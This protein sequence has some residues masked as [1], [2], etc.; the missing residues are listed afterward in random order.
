MRALTAPPALPQ[1]AAE[2]SYHP[3]RI[4]FDGVLDWSRDAAWI[5]RFIRAF[6]F[7]P[8]PAAKTWLEGREIQLR[9][10]VGIGPDLPGRGPGEIVPGD[11]DQ[12]AVSCGRGSLTVRNVLVKGRE[13]ALSDLV[14][15]A[16][17]PWVF[18]AL[19]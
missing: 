4:P 11:G 3:K 1:N 18:Q 12:A 2:A 6:T 14:R 7:P 19:P 10:P 16:A 5:E 17:G 9:A 8:Y 15:D 13:V